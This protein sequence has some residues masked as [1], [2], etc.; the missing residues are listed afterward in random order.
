MDY[1]KP[2]RN[3]I[4]TPLFLLEVQVVIQDILGNVNCFLTTHLLDEL[5][6]CYRF[7]A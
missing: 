7:Q 2:F 4:T 3:K 5:K 6:I 1:L